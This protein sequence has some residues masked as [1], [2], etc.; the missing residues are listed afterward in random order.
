M[1]KSPTG[2]PKRVADELVASHRE[3][4]LAAGFDESMARALAGNRRSDLHAL[5]ELSELGC[6]P[7][8]DARILAPLDA[9]PDASLAGMDAGPSV[10]AERSRRGRLESRTIR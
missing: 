5:L 6:P 3:R 10:V 4:L 7:E 8:T 2:Q 1:R 9:G